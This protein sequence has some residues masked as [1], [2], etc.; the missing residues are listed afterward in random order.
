MHHVNK[1]AA[2]LEDILEDFESTMI[3][4]FQDLC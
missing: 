1:F 3:E 4:K 2:I